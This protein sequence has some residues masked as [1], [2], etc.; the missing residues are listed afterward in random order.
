MFLFTAPLAHVCE[1]LPLAGFDSGFISSPSTYGQCSR[2]SRAP[3]HHSAVFTLTLA[4]LAQLLA[5]LLPKRSDEGE[6]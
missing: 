5:L 2:L 4:S 6:G 3:E 1:M